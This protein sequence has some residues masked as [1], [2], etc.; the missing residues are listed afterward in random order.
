M[1]YCFDCG[2]EFAKIPLDDCV[3]QEIQDIM[4]EHIKKK[5]LIK[6]MANKEIEEM[7]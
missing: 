3:A 2:G 6:G 4:I 7:I 5:A 1:D